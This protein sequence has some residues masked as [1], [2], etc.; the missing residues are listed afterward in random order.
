[1]N[2]SIFQT[3]FLFPSVALCS[4]SVLLWFLVEIFNI[5]NKV[6]TSSTWWLGHFEICILWMQ[7]DNYVCNIPASRQGNSCH[8]LSNFFYP[9]GRVNWRGPWITSSFEMSEIIRTYILMIEVI[10]L[11][12]ERYDDIMDGW[13]LQSYLWIPSFKC[14]IKIK[15][16]YQCYPKYYT[17]YYEIILYV[18]CVL[19]HSFKGSI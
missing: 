19:L 18:L 13:Y 8:T 5:M 12:L 6:G 2:T 15:L 7:M 1:M 9:F 10:S 14:K 17:L 4:E 3:P 16:V 11:D